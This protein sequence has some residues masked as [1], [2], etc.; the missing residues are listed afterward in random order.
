[1][2]VLFYVIIIENMKSKKN[3][4]FFLTI[5]QKTKLYGK[6]IFCLRGK[7]KDTFEKPRGIKGL[8]L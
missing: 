4:Y 2:N 6:T 1:M 8:R 5:R 7:K 3:K